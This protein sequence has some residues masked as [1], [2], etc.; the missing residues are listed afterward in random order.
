MRCRINVDQLQIYVLHDGV[1]LEFPVLI[2]LHVTVV[3]L[4]VPGLSQVI[5]L[6]PKLGNKLECIARFRKAVADVKHV[7][8]RLWLRR[9]RCIRDVGLNCL[10][11]ARTDTDSHH[12]HVPH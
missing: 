3:N 4:S 5:K 2:F 10:F 6:Q 1:L 9:S 11:R 8:L 12:R 7:K